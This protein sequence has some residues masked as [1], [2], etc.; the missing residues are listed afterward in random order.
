MPQ[1]FAILGKS[2]N[3]VY[4]AE[5][6][7]QQGQQGQLQKGFP[8]HLKELNPF[9]M[10]ASLDI[11]EDLQWKLNSNVQH[12][13]NNSGFGSFLRSKNVNVTDNCY[14]GKVDHFY[15]LAITAY[16]T[17]SGMKFVMIHGNLDKNSTQV[18][19]NAVKSFYQEVHELYIKTL[20]NPF[21]KIN[22]PITSAAFDTRVRSLARKYL[23]K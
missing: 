4:E 5:F 10:H 17:F 21:Y 23:N 18:D 20:M 22:D 2:D 15:G 9:I 12:G 8:Q 11:I 19:D 3:P 1:Y 6:T 7:T 13:T 16:L 14:L